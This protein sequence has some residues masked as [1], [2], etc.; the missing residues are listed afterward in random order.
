M[1]FYII[2]CYGLVLSVAFASLQASNNTIYLDKLTALMAISSAAIIEHLIA[3][4]KIVLYSLA[5]TTAQLASGACIDIVS[6]IV[7]AEE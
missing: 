4:I 5:A 7:L 6:A 1:Y 3:Q 2:A